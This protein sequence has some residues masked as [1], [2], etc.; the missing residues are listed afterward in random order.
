MNQSDLDANKAFVHCD[1][2]ISKWFHQGFDFLLEKIFTILPLDTM[3][4]CKMASKDWQKIV[5][6]IS[7]HS[8]IPRLV[9]LQ[10][11][12]IHK[13][14]L[15]AKPRVHSVPINGLQMSL[16][17]LIADEKNIVLCFKGPNDDIKKSSLQILDSVNLT[18]VH[19]LNLEERLT[20]LTIVGNGQEAKNEMRLGLNKKFLV[21]T[22]V[23]HSTYVVLIWNR[24]DN[25]SENVLALK[26]KTLLKKYLNP[27]GWGWGLRGLGCLKPSIFDDF[28]YL[29]LCYNANQFTHEIVFSCWNMADGTFTDL[30]RKEFNVFAKRRNYFRICLNIKTSHILVFG[31]THNEPVIASL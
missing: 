28:V 18:S 16:A 26:Q 15:M 7:Q 19:N 1:D 3:I 14:W 27:F 24:E 10:D 11:V 20:A 5:L 4:A 8:R 2:I 17:N 22:L 12:Q 9:K 23:F 6:N 30:I 13:E 25:F 29:P 31:T 21:A